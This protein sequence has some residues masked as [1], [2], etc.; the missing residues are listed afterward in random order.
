M[1]K[2]EKYVKEVATMAEGMGHT[3]DA[4][5]RIIKI[6]VRQPHGGIVLLLYFG[7]FNL[8]VIS[9]HSQC[10]A[11][12]A[13]PGFCELIFKSVPARLDEATGPTM[14][15]QYTSLVVEERRIVPT[16]A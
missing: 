2:Y 9:F 5:R 13:L 11:S 14:K 6:N 10:I 4:D 1:A 8:D 3:V 12:A 7:R 15:Y 16:E